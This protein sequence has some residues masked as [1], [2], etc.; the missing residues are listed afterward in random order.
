VNRA[1]SAKASTS[2]KPLST[3]TEASP[4]VS[5]AHA[6]ALPSERPITPSGPGKDE[7]TWASTVSASDKSRAK[8]GTPVL[9]P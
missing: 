1:E 2:V 5:I 8:E 9:A 7:R 4:V 6:A 3:T